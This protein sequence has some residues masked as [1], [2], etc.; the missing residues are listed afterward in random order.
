MSNMKTKSRCIQLKEGT[1]YKKTHVFIT[2]IK[3]PNVFPSKIKSK[4]ADFST[5]F[6]ANIKQEMNM[7]AWCLAF[8]Y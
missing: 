4:F 7:T 6:N 3:L 8:T 1:R 5:S 2:E